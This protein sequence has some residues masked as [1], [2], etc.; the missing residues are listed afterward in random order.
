MKWILYPLII[1]LFSFPIQAQNVD[2]NAMGKELHFQNL[3]DAKSDDNIACYR[4]PAIV[5]A[6]NG[7]LIAAIGQRVPSCD[8]LRTNENINIVIR[9]SDNNGLTW[10]EIQTVVDYPEGESASDPSLIVDEVTREVFLFYNYM[11]LTNEKD[12]YYL[13]YIKSSDHGKTWSE[14]VDI[15][16]QITRPEWHNDFMFITSG[17]GIQTREGKL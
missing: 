2:T 7:D 13:K 15:T 12:V 4:I 5:T 6:P 9:R 1:L 17:R 8:D 14:P 10:S 16:A 3:F 11:D